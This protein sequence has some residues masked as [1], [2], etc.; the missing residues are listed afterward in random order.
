VDLVDHSGNPFAYSP[1]NKFGVTAQVH[2]PVDPALGSPYFTATWYEQSKVWFSDLSD[3]E[4]FSAQGTYDL[5]NLRLDWTNVLS[6]NFDASAFVDNLT[7]RT[8]KVSENAYLHLLG[9]SAA[10]YGP[11]R[12]FGLELRYSFGAGGN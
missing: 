1:K 8:Y 11:P 3:E 12:M 2:L 7:D 6:S 10:I 4:P 9:T 5:V